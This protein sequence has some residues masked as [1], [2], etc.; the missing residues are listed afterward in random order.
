[1]SK[2]CA[3]IAS[4]FFMVAVLGLVACGGQTVKTEGDVVV[5]DTAESTATKDEITAVVRGG[6]AEDKPESLV[7]VMPQKQGDESPIAME[8]IPAKEDQ[9]KT[10]EDVSAVEAGAR[11]I[12][13]VPVVKKQVVVPAVTSEL[14]AVVAPV[15]ETPEAE[16]KTTPVSAGPNYF[17]V[18][19]GP[20]KPGHPAYGKGHAMGFLVDG[21]SGKEL[22]VERG[23]IYTF[24][25]ATNQKHDVYLS[26]KAVGWGGAPFAAGGRGIHLQ[27]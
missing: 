22:V 25:I 4:F 14:E 15:A 1:M 2:L 20:K 19:V 6:T 18:T 21:I 7:E 9:T 17:V 26:K 5:V 11:P 23:K 24:D 16:K 27:R 10:K 12:V 13:D 8:P 3:K